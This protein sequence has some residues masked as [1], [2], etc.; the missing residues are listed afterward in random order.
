LNTITEDLNLERDIYGPFGI[1]NNGTHIFVTHLLGSKIT[2]HDLDGNQVGTLISESGS[3][4]GQIIA[5]YGVVDNGT[6]YLVLDSGNSRIQIFDRGMNYISEIFAVPTYMDHNTTH[7]FVLDYW[8]HGLYVLD[9]SGNWV[10]QLPQTL[11]F[12]E[13]MAVTEDRIYIS[14]AEYPELIDIYDHQGNDLGRFGIYAEPDFNVNTIGGLAVYKDFIFHAGEQRLG[15]YSTVGTPHAPIYQVNP[16]TPFLGLQSITIVNGRLYLSDFNGNAIHVFAIN[17]QDVSAS[18]GSD[19]VR[20]SWGSPSKYDGANVTHFNVY[21]GDTSG[22]YNPIAQLSAETMHFIDT[23]VRPGETYYYAVTA[24]NDFGETEYSEEV[25]VTMDASLIQ[26]ITE[27]DTT[28]E[29][30]ESDSGF[31]SFNIM[32]IPIA[33]ALIIYLRKR[34]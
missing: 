20:V 31:L 2:I 4:P 12:P 32:M 7:F 5:P 25:S 23:A 33:S 13:G 26:I 16:T 6:H 30:T 27:F 8:G 19:H 34:K 15:V 3:D 1:D 22:H 29:I 28:V 24:L 18:A 10:W 17:V 21:R 9:L 14:H 11:Y